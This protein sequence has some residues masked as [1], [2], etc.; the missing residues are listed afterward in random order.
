MR[1]KHTKREDPC[2]RP[3]LRA[4]VSAKERTEAEVFL[5]LGVRGLGGNT[6][7]VVA[8]AGHPDV[9]GLTPGDAP[10][11]LDDPVLGGAIGVVA[12]VEDTVVELGGGAVGLIVDS[13]LVELE[14]HVGGIDGNGDGSNETDG[15]LEGAL[16]SRGCDV[17][18][19]R[20]GGTLVGGAV[21]AASVLSGVGVRG[22]GVDTLVVDDVL[23][24]TVHLTSVAAEVSVAP[25]AIE[26][27]LFRETD[28]SVS[29]KLPC[30]LN[31]TGGRERPAS[32]ALSLVLDTGDGT[33]V[34]PVLGGGGTKPT[35]HA[36]RSMALATGI[37]KGGILMTVAEHTE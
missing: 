12:D 6:A 18:V 5:N 28:K 8:V 19:T 1:C 4:C 23:E 9:S 13:R 20:D 36:P 34:T 25:R 27:V 16:A 22:L 24:G 31:G 29:S 10:G 17:R 3:H 30:T 2:A 35:P 11:V 15:V 33:V 21:V 14:G 7:V 32:S 37:L 26:E